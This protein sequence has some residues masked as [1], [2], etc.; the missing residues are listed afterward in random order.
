MYFTQLLHSDFVSKAPTLN[1]ISPQSPLLL[2][3]GMSMVYLFKIGT[4]DAILPS[5]F[6]RALIIELLMKAGID[7]TEH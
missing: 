5:P 4:I 6:D 1:S 7:V 3:L 2:A